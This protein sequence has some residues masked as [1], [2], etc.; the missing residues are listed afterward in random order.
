MVDIL[1]DW[2]RY[3]G[4]YGHFMDGVVEETIDKY[5]GKCISVSYFV[6]AII[7]LWHVARNIV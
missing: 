5:S 1:V 3:G 4:A 7:L 6:E 2:L